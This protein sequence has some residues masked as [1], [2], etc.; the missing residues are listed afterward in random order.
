[1]ELAGV[2]L[3]MLVV[4]SLCG[5]ASGLASSLRSSLPPGRWSF[6]PSVTCA[7]EQ[8]VF[9]YHVSNEAILCRE[10]SFLH[11]F[12]VTLCWHVLTWFWMRHF[13]LPAELLK[14][15]SMCCFYTVSACQIFAQLPPLQIPS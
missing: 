1:M 9:S 15:P 2:Q 5:T 6:S 7:I 11:Q 12:C 4:T 14:L 3:S 10:T 13:W 8:S